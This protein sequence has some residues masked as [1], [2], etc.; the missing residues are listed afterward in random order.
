MEATE[1]VSTRLI[2]DYAVAEMLGVDV[3]T[4]R[5]WRKPRRKKKQG[6]PEGPPFLK[7]SRSVYRYR[8]NDVIAWIESCQHL[9]EAR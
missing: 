1:S 9:V 2:D 3:I 8:L 7:L 4:V 6:P 5:R